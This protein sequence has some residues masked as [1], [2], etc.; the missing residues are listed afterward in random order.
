MMTMT[1]RFASDEGFSLTEMLVVSVLLSIILAAAWMASQ[2]VTTSADRMMARNDAQTTGQQA[3]ERMAREIRQ[4]QTI[5]ASTIRLAQT[6]NT[7]N[8]LSFYADVDHDGFIEK[9][10]YSLTA[11]GL[12][13]RTLARTIKIAPNHDDFGAPSPPITLAKL[14][15]GTNNLFAA[16]TSE[17]VPAVTTDPATTRAIQITMN[18]VAKSGADT[19]TVNFPPTLVSVRAFGVW[20]QQ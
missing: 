20:D 10:T 11:A 6:T 9:V 1:R 7:S 15:P 18:C 12:L 5:E 16:Y 19:V 4:A 3:L 13:Q 8:Y 2:V 17:D 14:T